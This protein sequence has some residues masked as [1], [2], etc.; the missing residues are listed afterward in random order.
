MTNLRQRPG[1]QP[2]PTEGK[3]DVSRW[4]QDRVRGAQ[5]YRWYVSRYDVAADLEI[6]AQLGE[7]RYGHRLETHNGRDALRDAY[8]EALDLYHYLCQVQMEQPERPMSGALSL[9]LDVIVALKEARLSDVAEQ[10]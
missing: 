8:D 10:S 1:D 2:L 5:G 7:Q 6:R 3:A 9:T 4:A